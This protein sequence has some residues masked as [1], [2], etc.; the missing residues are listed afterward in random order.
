MKKRRIPASEGRGFLVRTILELPLRSFNLSLLGSSLSSSGA[1]ERV[2]ET[3]ELRLVKPL[4]LGQNLKK[5]T[6]STG[7]QEIPHG[8]L[9]LQKSGAGISI[10][11]FLEVFQLLKQTQG[12]QEFILLGVTNFLQTQ[13]FSPF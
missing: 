12:H 2:L 1:A 13:D 8:E 5:G 11:S 6:H 7:N 9:I 4:A 10:R 3:Q